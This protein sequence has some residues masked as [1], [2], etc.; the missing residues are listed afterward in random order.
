VEIST[1]KDCRGSRGASPISHR[2]GYGRTEWTRHAK[3]QADAPY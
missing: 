2:Q 1:T 3:Q